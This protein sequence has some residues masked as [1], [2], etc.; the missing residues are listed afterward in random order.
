MKGT[1]RST[2]AEFYSRL[3]ARAG[4]I[5]ARYR[6]LTPASA[7]LHE[8][9][10]GVF[11]GGYSRDAVIRK[12]YSPF[13]VKG[14]GAIL[15]D[16]DGR[17]ITD[18]WFNATSLPLG[19]ADPCVVEAAADQVKQGTAFFGQTEKELKLAGILCERLPSAERVRF[20]NSGSEAVTM[21][22]RAARAFTGRDLLVKFE[23]S[24]HGTYDDVSWSVSPPADKVGPADAPTPV[25]ETAGLPSGL[26]RILV[27]PFNDA[28]V[29]EG[30]VRER[31]G[32]IAAIIVE[33]MANRMGM[34]LPAPAFLSRIRELCDELGLV[35]IFD[36]II[37]FRLGFHGAQ[38]ALGVTPDVTTLGKV[39]GGGFPVGGFAGLAEILAVTEPGRPNRM[40]HAGTFNANP[41]TM[42]A[43]KATMDALTPETF[44]SLNAAGERIRARLREI[45][46]GLPLRVT[47]AGSLFKISATPHEIANHRDTL[48]VDRDWEKILS[49]ELLNEGFLL[50]S[51][52][53]GCVSTVTTDAHIDGLLSAVEE[54]VRG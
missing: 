32:E 23:G 46:E 38:G 48:T 24:Y 42:A 4:E 35:L 7:K 9:A 15:T 21:A 16:Q 27:L 41:V 11:P 8:S 44:N 10:K 40:G 20:T 33:P 53:Q 2:A 25:P 34:I 17:A 6:K 5:E 18:F 36:E 19:H 3:R 50:T 12:P 52:L 47:G 29:L 28:E 43:G 49:L 30:A 26:G 31:A 51:N 1:V 14:E 37:A 54:A 45:C 39:I 22:I 13:I